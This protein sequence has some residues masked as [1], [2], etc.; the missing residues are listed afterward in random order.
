MNNDS[1]VLSN[2]VELVCYNCV[3]ASSCVWYKPGEAC[4]WNSAGTCKISSTVKQPSHDYSQIVDEDDEYKG[5]G[6]FDFG[7][8]QGYC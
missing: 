7:E 4:A 2:E 3:H 1:V 5:M 8:Y 6:E